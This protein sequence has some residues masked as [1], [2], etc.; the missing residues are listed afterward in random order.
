MNRRHLAEL[1][2]D[3]KPDVG[4]RGVYPR[5]GVPLRGRFEQAGNGEPEHHREADVQLNR[6]IPQSDEQPAMGA[7]VGFTATMPSP[8]QM[9]V[10]RATP[11]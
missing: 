2:F 7:M 8:R 11:R 1:N 10:A 5:A 6:D 3:L 9:Q 4:L